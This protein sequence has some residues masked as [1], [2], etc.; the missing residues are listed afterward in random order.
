MLYASCVLQRNPENG[1][2]QNGEAKQLLAPVINF[3]PLI[4]LVLPNYW[5]IICLNGAM[6]DVY[7]QV[8]TIDED[9]PEDKPQKSLND[10]Q[11]VS[12]SF[13]ARNISQ[14]FPRGFHS[15]VWLLY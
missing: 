6:L 7:L 10:K 11:Q 8:T 15:F 2:V 12:I 5:N 1:H 13:N 14:V 3:F 9:S 4:S